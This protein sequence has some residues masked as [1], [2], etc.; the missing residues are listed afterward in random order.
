MEVASTRL[1]SVNVDPPEMLAALRAGLDAGWT[2][3]SAAER[4]W[5]PRRRGKQP[6]KRISSEPLAVVAL[7]RD[8][9]AGVYVVRAACGTAAVR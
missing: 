8:M 5:L 7:A 9:P 1:V 2:F 3:L 4:R 6:S